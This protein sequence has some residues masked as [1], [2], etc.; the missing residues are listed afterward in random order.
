MEYV[1]FLMQAKHVSRYCEFHQHPPSWKGKKVRWV[2]LTLTIT[3]Y[4][5]K[6]ARGKPQKLGEMKMMQE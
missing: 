3:I 2:K 4:N 1:E 6:S 5:P